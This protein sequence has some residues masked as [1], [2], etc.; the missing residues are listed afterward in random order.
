M[1]SPVHVDACLGEHEVPQVEE[2]GQVVHGGEAVVH[3]EAAVGQPQRREDRHHARQHLDHLKD[4]DN[5][6]VKAHIHA[7]VLKAQVMSDVKCDFF[8]RLPVYKV[9]TGGGDG[10]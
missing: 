7:A 3:E 10:V 4:T 2:W 6:V 8:R 9:E 1:N 5:T